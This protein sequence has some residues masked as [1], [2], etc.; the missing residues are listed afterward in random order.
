MAFP[1]KEFIELLPDVFNAVEAIAKAGGDPKAEMIRI[2]RG[3]EAQAQV[4][5]EVSAAMDRKFGPDGT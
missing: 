5:G 4:E 2:Q 1:A 3:W